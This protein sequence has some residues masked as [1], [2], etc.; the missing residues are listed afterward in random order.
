MKDKKQQKEEKKE[1]LTKEDFMKAL[2]KVSKKKPKPS[3]EKET[4][5]TSE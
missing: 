1:V 3:R 5:K 2:K 4:R